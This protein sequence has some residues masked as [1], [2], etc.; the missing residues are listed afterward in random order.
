MM[1]ENDEA[2]SA[3]CA[4]AVASE[5]G[6]IREGAKVGGGIEFSFLYGGY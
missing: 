2:S 1:N 6:E 4:R 5:S 3:G